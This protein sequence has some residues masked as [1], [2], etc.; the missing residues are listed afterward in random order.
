[1]MTEE[2]FAPTS[3]RRNRYLNGYAD[4]DFLLNGPALGLEMSL[5]ICQ[6]AA[7]VLVVEGGGAVLERRSTHLWKTVGAV[8]I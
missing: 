2:D 8:Q 6:A 5:G 3:T 7:V 4:F 1:M